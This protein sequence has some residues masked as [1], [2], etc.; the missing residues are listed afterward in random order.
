MRSA[1]LFLLCLCLAHVSHSSETVNIVTATDL[2]QVFKNAKGS[3]VDVNIEVKADLDFSQTSLILPLGASPSGTCV[4]YSGVLHGNGHIIKGLLM[5]NKD[6]P[7]EFNH[8]G[9]FCRLKNAVIENLVIDSSCLFAG[10]SAGSL[11]V[12][13]TGSLTVTNVINKASVTGTSSVGGFVGEIKN[14]VKGDL[15]SFDK[16]TNEGKITG[17]NGVGGLV[18]FIFDNQNSRITVSSSANNGIITSDLDVVGGLIGHVDK[19][20]GITLK[21][22]ES[23][24]N[25]VVTSPSQVGG[26]VGYVGSGNESRTSMIISK[27]TNNGRVTGDGTVGGL[28]GIIASNVTMEFSRCVNDGRLI[29]G[30]NGFVGGFVG[31][32]QAST[33]VKISSSTNKHYVIGRGSYSAGFIGNTFSDDLS[34]PVTLVILNSANE[35]DI[36]SD[37][38]TACGMFCVNPTGTR[39]VKSVVINSINKGDIGANIYGYGVST[40][41]TTARNVVSMGK[42]GSGS[43]SFWESSTDADLLYGMKDK[44]H[45]CSSRVK[46]FEFNW[47]SGFFEVVPGGNRVHDLLNDVAQR[48]HYGMLW[49]SKLNLVDTKASSL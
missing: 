48:E 10:Y 8:A 27:S 18:G 19:N 5:S 34:N 24:N 47:F 30:K 16:C 43:F 44:C 29:C 41:V 7:L 12:S 14:S 46:L 4:P 45:S 13:V 25:G 31:E 42:V 26:L 21:I 9:L 20:S 17:D 36:S 49:T 39:G 38:G 6:K 40:V 15:V 37:N 35:G 32:L 2:I 22:S 28:V 1:H 11:A 33:S 23:T 3:A